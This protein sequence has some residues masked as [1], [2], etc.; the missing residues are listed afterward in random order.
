MSQP[1]PLP[2]YWRTRE[3]NPGSKGVVRRVR[4]ITCN[5][6]QQETANIIEH[7]KSCKKP[8]VDRDHDLCVCGRKK[9]LFGRA[10]FQCSDIE[11]VDA[12]DRLDRLTGTGKYK[13]APEASL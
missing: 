3:G 11:D 2:S 13:V 4:L 9:A 10:C 5:I 6:C 8:R 12:F 7:R 1:I